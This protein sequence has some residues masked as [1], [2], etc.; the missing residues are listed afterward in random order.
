LPDYSGEVTGN[1]LH[2]LTLLLKEKLQLIEFRS[3]S[4]QARDRFRAFLYLGVE[5]LQETLLRSTESLTA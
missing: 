2:S 1:V 5:S 3:K 4:F